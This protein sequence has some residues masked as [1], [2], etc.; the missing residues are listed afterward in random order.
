MGSFFYGYVLTQVPGGRLSEQYGAK[1]VFGW[2]IFVTS[3]LTMLS[4]AAARM[5]KGAFIGI[6][7]LEGLGEGVTFPSMCAMLARWIPPLERNT[8][9]AAVFSGSNFGTI[10]AMPLSGYLAS[11]EWMGGWPLAF[12]VFGALGVV[13][14]VVW[15]FVVFDSPAS[16]P[17]ISLQEKEYIAASLGP[18]NIQSKDDSDFPWIEIFTCVPFWAIMVTQCG[19]SWAFYTQLT[20]MPTYM[21][22]ILHFGL[23]ANAML[24]SVPY[25]T[26]WV[27][28]LCFCR[29]ADWLIAKQYLSPIASIKIFNSLASVVPSI[30]FIGA[31]LAGC[32][33]Q[34][35][36]II[37][38]ITG[39]FVGA[40]YAGNQMNHIALS[41][42]YAGTMYGMTNGVA[43][44]CG[45]LAPYT[46]GSI[47]NNNETVW[48]WQ[49]VFFLAAA[50]NIVTNIIYVILGSADEQP[51]N[52]PRPKETYNAETDGQT[53][54]LLG[55]PE[56]SYR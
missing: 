48:R 32:D 29:F 38:S 43:N 33:R 8:F 47:I 27:S 55:V 53:E 5:G 49:L 20:E 19:M 11:V 41:P 2:G 52:H 1:R 7:V 9:A 31:A 3:L 39:S 6:R 51:F 34:L 50:V 23:E 35:V 24:T 28:S 4:P 44:L 15:W 46:I 22:H 56:V 25:F 26:S 12:Y 30:G 14:S 42:R 37:I 13:W 54:P 36:M 45:F 21:D 18:E 40:Q 10:I 16:H 17:R